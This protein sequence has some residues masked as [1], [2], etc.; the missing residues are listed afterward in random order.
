MPPVITFRSPDRFA[1][2]PQTRAQAL[3]SFREQ[4]GSKLRSCAPGVCKYRPDNSRSK[5]PRQRT[6]SCG[7]T[8]KSVDRRLEAYF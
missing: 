5:D 3:E 7:R 1:G 6:R 8:D 4:W 2:R